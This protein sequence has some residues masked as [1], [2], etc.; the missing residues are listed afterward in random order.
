MFYIINNILHTFKHKSIVALIL[1]NLFPLYGV[2]YL[3]WNISQI[4]VLYWFENVIIGFYNVLKMLYNTNEN[5]GDIHMNG[6]PLQGS[7]N[8]AKVFMIPFFIMHYGMF[9]LIHGVFIF[10][11]FVFGIKNGDGLQ[12]EDISFIPLNAAMIFVSH[13]LSFFT[14]YLGN[15]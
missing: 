10:M 13:G 14:N 6:K 9:T 1:A 12:W 2:Y 11:Y 7:L 8:S 15:N 5:L 4:V 3:G